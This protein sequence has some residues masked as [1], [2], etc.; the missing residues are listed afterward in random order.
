[1]TIHFEM[2]LRGMQLIISAI[3][4]CECLCAGGGAEWRFSIYGAPAVSGSG[5]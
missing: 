1:M 3:N 2:L 4:I 5:S